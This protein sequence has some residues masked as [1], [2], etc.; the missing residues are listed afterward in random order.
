M[1]NMMSNLILISKAMK[2][3][4]FLII[5][6]AA[7]FISCSPII[8]TSYDA[9]TEDTDQVFYDDLSPYG[10]W[11]NDPDYGYVWQ[12]NVDTDFRPYYT[13]GSWVYSDDYGWTWDSGYSWGWAPFHYGRWFYD[14]Y[15]GWL[16]A[17]GDEWAPAWVTWGQ[18]DGYYAWAPMPPGIN[19]ATGWTP[20]A[21][22]W[23]FV[24][25]GSFGRPDIHQYFVRNNIT[26]IN[27]ITIINN[28]AADRMGVRY[29]RG[30][31]VNNVEAY[32][33]RRVQRVTIAGAAR[34]GH[35]RSGNQLNIYRPVIK[36]SRGDSRPAPQK[37]INYNREG[38]RVQ[39][40]NSQ[41]SDQGRQPDQNKRDNMRP[42]VIPG[43]SQGR[44]SDQNKH[45]NSA[46]KTRP[47]VIPGNNQGTRPAQPGRTDNVPGNRGNTTPPDN[48]AGGLSAQPN[49]GN[50][51]SDGGQGYRTGNP[52]VNHIDSG[53]RGHAA[54]NPADQ[55]QPRRP[56]L[57]QNTNRPNMDRP[58]TV[59]P[60]NNVQK[61]PGRPQTNNKQEQGVRGG[62]VKPPQQKDKKQDNKKDKPRPARQKVDPKKQR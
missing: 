25:A 43:N 57:I 11:I 58:E 3:L 56:V 4:F 8:Y 24:E 39:P 45:D 41:R 2:R 27:R 59:P 54:N 9:G 55:P 7:C 28:R 31:S 30:P 29:Y 5:P 46:D 26:V 32:S 34:P 47:V 36:Q 51:A 49:K 17:P 60:A 10:Q 48:R 1:V 18:T 44:Q 20:D 50:A 6:L 33:R 21:R 13:N 52:P 14:D 61:L 23:N 12:P 15:Y 62:S 22:D 40:G 53:Q 16:W 37:V 38:R 35:S 19:P 42:E